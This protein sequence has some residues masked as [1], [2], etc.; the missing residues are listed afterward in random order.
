[1]RGFPLTDGSVIVLV[2]GRIRTPC[3]RLVQREYR[4]ITTREYYR[5]A[6]EARDTAGRESCRTSAGRTVYGGGGVYPDVV[7]APP[8][9]DAIW[10]ARILEQELPLQWV[11]GYLSGPGSAVALDTIVRRGAL[12]SAAVADFRAFALAR[13]I[14]L[15]NEETAVA[16]LAR[17]LALEV[18]AAKWGDA[19]YYRVAAAA[20]PE[21]REAVRALDR[22][23][24]PR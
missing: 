10:L 9:G 19:G 15:P 17:V 3:G 12:D 21:I 6:G 14:E 18:A 7:I 20:D 13:G 5:L 16:R 24:V 8:P 23:P 1:M 11:G 4:G 2:V 22:A